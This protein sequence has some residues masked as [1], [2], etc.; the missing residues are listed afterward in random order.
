MTTMLIMFAGVLVGA[1]VFP[2]GLKKWND[3]LQL[4]M[5]ALL[6]FTMGV[7]LG[8]RPGFLEELGAIGVKSLIFALV[9][10]LFSVALV[11]PLSRRFLERPGEEPGEKGRAE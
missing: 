3:R 7:S 1:T 6:I 11:Y 5:T 2:K 10:I 8:S 9:P 4:G